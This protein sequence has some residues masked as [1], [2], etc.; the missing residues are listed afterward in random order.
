[1]VAAKIK[2]PFTR[3]EAK[4]A[5]IETVRRNGLKDSGTWI[6]VSYGVL[7]A[8]GYFGVPTTPT[9]LVIAVPYLWFGG[10]QAQKAGMKVFISS[11]RA[12]PSQSIPPQLKHVN[13]LAYNLADVE[14]Q[15]AGADAPIVLDINGYVAEHNAAN[16]WLAKNSKLYTPSID[17]VLGGITR[18][19]IFEI[20]RANGIEAV[21]R[22]LAPF[23]LYTADEVFFSTSAG[24][25][26]PVIEINR[27]KI[28]GGKPGVLT[29]R[30]Q[31][32][33]FELHESK[34]YGTPVCP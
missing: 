25:V 16:V 26:V 2:P 8:P 27:R 19:T 14:A 10:V 9:Y 33:Y 17:G 34:K 6:Y 32:L 28:G 31:K 22:H 12:I 13:R 23:D 30:L 3:E 7:T 20:A 1:M 21:E 24:G 15:A 11:V 18:E 5:I 29:K 4:E